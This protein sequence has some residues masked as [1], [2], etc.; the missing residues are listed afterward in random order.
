MAW[1]SGATMRS[2]ALAVAIPR[3]QRH[4]DQ[5]ERRSCQRCRARMVG[6]SQTKR[7]A[8]DAKVRS[9]TEARLR[10]QASEDW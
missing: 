2:R 3:P 7:A 8:V 1:I 9:P 4:V 6:V 10:M 5:H